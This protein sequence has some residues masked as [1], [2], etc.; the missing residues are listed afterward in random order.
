MAALTAAAVLLPAAAAS[1]APLAGAIDDPAGDVKVPEQ[2][3]LAAAAVY[4]PAGIVRGAISTAAPASADTA[5]V[6]DLLLGTASRATGICDV[7]FHGTMYPAPRARSGA[8]RRR[9][10]RRR[11]GGRPERPGHAVRL[12]AGNG[13]DPPVGPLPAL[14]G[15]S[16]NCGVALTTTAKVVKG[17][18]T[19][20]DYTLVFP[21]IAGS[22]GTVAGCQVVTR[23]VRRGDKLRVKCAGISGNVTV[24]LHRKRPRFRPPPRRAGRRRLGR[25]PPQRPQ[26]RVPR[27]RVAGPDPDGR[28]L[29]ARALTRGLIGRRPGPAPSPRRA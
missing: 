27:R 5:P 3:I 9:A 18:Y 13:F 6:V 7:E 8:V 16:W 4:D 2:D 29:R 22:S 14:A 11:P 12:T 21:L 23:K 1:A 26:G 20:A 28:A 10:G 17:D 24:R 19:D 25:H 15:K